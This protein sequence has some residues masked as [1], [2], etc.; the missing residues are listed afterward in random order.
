[1]GIGDLLYLVG[2]YGYLAVFFGVMM[3]ESAGGRGRVRPS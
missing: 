2:R 3:L 1:M